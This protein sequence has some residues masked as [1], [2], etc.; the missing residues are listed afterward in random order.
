L[1]F[2]DSNVLI[3]LSSNDPRWSDWSAIQ[4]A[5]AGTNGQL[6]INAIVVAELAPGFATQALLV[7]SFEMLA[8]RIEPLDEAIACLAGQ[9]FAVYRRSQPG[10]GAILA[11]F[12]IGAHASIL[13]T[14]LLT[15]D[16]RIYRRYFPEL[17]L[18]TPETDHD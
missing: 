9:R 13:G 15:R 7:R 5:R 10:R 3:D 17:S 16:A 14:A 4:I 1:T 6:S 8:L 12:I 18:I 2:V 11:D